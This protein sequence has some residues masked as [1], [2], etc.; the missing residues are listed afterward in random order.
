[1]LLLIDNYFSILKLLNPFI[2]HFASEC[3]EEFSKYNKIN[4]N[5]PKTDQKLLSE[6]K[7][8][9]VIQINGKKRE[10]LETTKDISENEILEM[11]NN[12]DKLKSYLNKKEL[13]KKIFVPN[14]IINLIIK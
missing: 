6:E 10:I 13:I 4:Y 11:I 5:W 8:K 12:N 1:M 7:I 9:I 14:K 2:P 3:L